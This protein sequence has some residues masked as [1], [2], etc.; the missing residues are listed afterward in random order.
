MR[1]AS[2]HDTFPLHLF[3][4][5]PLILPQ[6]NKA[7]GSALTRLNRR[8]CRAQKPSNCRTLCIPLGGGIYLDPGETAGSPSTGEVVTGVVDC[9]AGPCYQSVQ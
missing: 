3:I 8:I 9:T 1:C 5:F 6:R 2:G 7:A 4:S